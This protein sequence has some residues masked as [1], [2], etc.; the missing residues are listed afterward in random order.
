MNYRI[1][2]GVVGEFGGKVL[3]FVT[4]AEIL[5]GV[6]ESGTL[7]ATAEHL[8][9]SY[10]GV[11]GKLE[12]AHEALGQPLVVKSKGH[13]S[14]LT[15]AGEQLLRLVRDMRQRAQAAAQREIAPMDEELRR[16][17][18]LGRPAL[19]LA[20]SHDILL[21]DCESEGLLEGWELRFMGSLK[22]LDALESGKV[23]LAG[24]HLPENVPGMVAFES[25]FSDP[26]Y[27]I[28]PLLRREQG[29]IVARGNPL[30][31]HGMDDLIRPD[32]RFINRQRGAGTRMWL[33]HLLRSRGL[34]PA[35]IRGY[36]R[37]EFTHFAVAAAVAA[38]AADVAFA[39]RA[40]TVGLALEFIPIGFES[41]FIC[42]GRELAR[43]ARVRSFI[44]TV[45]RRLDKHAGYAAAEPPADKRKRSRA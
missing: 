1:S 44:D 38:G 15:P 14:H 8:K 23:N 36:G 43:D 25:L 10:R 20:C 22:A 18:A 17:L 5:A 41:Y 39:Q 35:A 42:G 2:V 45:A 12:Q 11:W 33:D 27:F 16:L 24:F 7:R 37:E 19:R 4:L 29:L 30:D 21:A 6:A 34:D 3:D 26:R 40:A 28:H 13:G 31:I 32:V 9:L